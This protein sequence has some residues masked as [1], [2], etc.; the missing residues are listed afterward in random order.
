MRDDAQNHQKAAAKDSAE[1]ERTLRMNMDAARVS[2][3]AY[4]N[5]SPPSPTLNPVRR[6]N[7]GDEPNITNNEHKNEYE[8]KNTENINI[9]HQEQNEHFQTGMEYGRKVEKE[10][11][12]ERER[13]RG[14]ASE[15]ER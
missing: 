6:I 10:Q 5:V 11:E 13:Q 12:R 8:N 4:A 3:Q 2:V 14:R 1:R 15:R 7:Y 9:T